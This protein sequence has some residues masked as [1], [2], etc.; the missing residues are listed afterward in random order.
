VKDS[1]TYARKLAAHLRKLKQ[2]G[3]IHPEAPPDPVTQLIQ[4]FLMWDAPLKSAQ[5]AHNRLMSAM[6]DTNDLRVSHPDEVVGVLGER[7][8]KAAE[9]AGRMLDVLQEV[10]ARAHVVSLDPLAKMGK[11]EAR[12]ALDAMPGMVSYVSA[13]VVLRSFDGHAI[14]V[15]NRLAQLLAENGLVDPE[16]APETVSSFLEHHVKAGEALDTF[17]RLQAWTEEKLEGKKARDD[18]PEKSKG[19]S[20]KTK[21]KTR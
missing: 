2:K 1:A 8:P 17:L 12:A 14:P 11:K 21:A 4:A 6:V 3:P 15:D 5:A 18:A 7:Y 19:K 9:R 16:A 10:F 20:P 13:M